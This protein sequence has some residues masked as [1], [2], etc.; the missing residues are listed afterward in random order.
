MSCIAMTESA[1]GTNVDNG[2]GTGCNNFGF[3]GMYQLSPT[4]I[5]QFAPPDCTREEIIANSDSCN[6]RTAVSVIQ[7]HGYSDWTGGGQ[8]PWNPKARSCVLKYDSGTS[9]PG[10]VVLLR[11]VYD[12]LVAYVQHHI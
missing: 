1:G 8:T 2:N 12:R 9:K 7:S 4:L 11:E 6:A 5:A 3:C 10:F